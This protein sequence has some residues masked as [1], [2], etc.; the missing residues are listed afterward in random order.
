MAYEAQPFYRNAEESERD[1]VKLLR[2]PD[3]RVRSPNMSDRGAGHDL[4]RKR[5]LATQIGPRLARH[6][7][8]LLRSRNMIMYF[9]K[10]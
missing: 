3:P 5:N 9:G 1:L 4:L 10:F 7:V 8:P 2:S 6:P